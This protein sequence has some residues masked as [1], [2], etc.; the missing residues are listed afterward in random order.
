MWCCGYN[1]RLITHVALVNMS[2]TN[3]KGF[4]HNVRLPTE[5]SLEGEEQTY[6]PA[7]R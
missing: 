1:P 4:D 3:E 7:R 5:Q 6:I 2:K